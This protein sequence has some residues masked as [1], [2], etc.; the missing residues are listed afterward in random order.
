V[1]YGQVHSELNP[2]LLLTA[3]LVSVLL[4]EIVAGREAG[5]LGTSAGEL[6]PE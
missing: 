1:N 3:T 2:D 4:F 5:L 6:H